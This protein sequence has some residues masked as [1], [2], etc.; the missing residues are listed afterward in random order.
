MLSDLHDSWTSMTAAAVLLLVVRVSVFV[1][2]AA[3]SGDFG[4]MI[5][6]VR[7]WFKM[8]VNSHAV[9]PYICY[10]EGKKRVA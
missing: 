7:C 4:C 3:G 1:R 10:S 2:A 6:R 9:R 5:L 8:F